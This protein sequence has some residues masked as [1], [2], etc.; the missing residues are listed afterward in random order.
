MASKNKLQQ[1]ADLTTAADLSTEEMMTIPQEVAP[2]LMDH[3][4]DP[5]RG[6]T[7]PRP[8]QL[9]LDQTNPSP[10]SPRPQM[11]TGT[12]TADP[13]RISHGATVQA[14]GMTG[15]PEGIEAIL[16]IAGMTAAWSASFWRVSVRDAH[17]Y[18]AQVNGG[19][20]TRWQTGVKPDA[21][22]QEWMVEINALWQDLHPGE[23][24]PFGGM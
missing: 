7:Q 6:S 4:N 13:A 9:N 24:L 10:T 23:A 12:S 5:R 19:R 8:Q 18:T 17:K 3:M 14:N 16:I 20:R 11:A 15:L 2:S 1:L 22:A 21:T